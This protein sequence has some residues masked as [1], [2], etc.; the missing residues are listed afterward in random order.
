MVAVSLSPA[1]LQRRFRLAER[2]LDIAAVNGPQV[3]VVAGPTG[4]VTGLIEQLRRAEVPCRQLRTTHAFHSRMLAGVGAELTDWIAGNITPEPAH[5]PLHLQCH[6]RLSPTPE[7]VCEPG[8]WA[9]HMCATVQFADAASTLLADPELA[10]VEIGPGQSLGAMIRA[11][12]AEPRQWPLILSTLPAA[13]D[14]R[15]DDAVLADCIARLW[16]LGVDLDWLAYHGRRPG[17]EFSEPAAL[18]GRVPLPTYPFQRQRYW[19]EGAAARIPRGAAGSRER[20]VG[21][22]LRHHRLAAQAARGPVA[23]P[24]GVAA[25]RGTGRA[26]SSSPATGWSTPGTAWP[27]RWWR[28]CAGCAEDRRQRD[29]GPAR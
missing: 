29:A 11:A 3:T 4:A 10:V 20:V 19:I 1:E 14:R 27:T 6:R 24:A 9:R 28:S 7:L 25:D 13:G 8:Y 17:S 23:A 22:H 26:A 16:L 15:P 21:D 12:G 5:R 2:E 18:P